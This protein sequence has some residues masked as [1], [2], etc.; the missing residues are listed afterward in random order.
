MV[1][2]IIIYCVVKKG[3]KINAVFFDETKIYKLI[4]YNKYYVTYFD[5]KIKKKIYTVINS[6]KNLY[7]IS[8]EEI[9]LFKQISSTGLKTLLFR[10][11]ELD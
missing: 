8:V 11:I 9:I 4:Y 6:S 10:S 7:S 2:P 1:C 5:T 3:P